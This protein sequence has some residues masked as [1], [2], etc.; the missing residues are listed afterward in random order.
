MNKIV[1]RRGH[2]EDFDERK[3]YASIFHACVSLRTPQ[4]Q[5]E[6]VAQK[7]TDE[8]KAWLSDKHEVTSG[9]IFREASRHFDVYSPEAAY[10]YKHFRVVS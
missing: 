1:K 9:D 5:A 2:T 3:L 7:V 6:L 10:M 4:A 8:V